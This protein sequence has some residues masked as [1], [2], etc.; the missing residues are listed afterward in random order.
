MHMLVA[1]AEAAQEFRDLRARLAGADSGEKVAALTEMARTVRRH[2]LLMIDRVDSD[3][4][5]PLAWL[6]SRY[7]CVHFHVVCPACDGMLYHQPF[8]YF[9]QEVVQ[10]LPHNLLVRWASFQGCCEIPAKFFPIV[11]A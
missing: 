4:D 9:V 10:Q 3:G 8:V 6:D 1:N 7:S 5:T 11:L 2:D